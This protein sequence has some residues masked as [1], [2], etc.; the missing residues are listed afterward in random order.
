MEIRN[1]RGSVPP[2]I[3]RRLV[4]DEPVYFFASGGGCLRGPSTYFVVTDQRVMG[5]AIR[6]SGCL[7]IGAST[8]N[9]DIPLQQISSVDT[10]AGGCLFSKYGVV[11]VRS[12]TA[13]N[14]MR[15]DNRQTAEEAT[16]VLQQ[17]L[18]RRGS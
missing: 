5:S 14:A 7:G 1:I 16:S 18:R 8:V 2:E 3:A 9:V 13:A 17:V 15:V 4:P 6:S 12:G 10:E 11:T